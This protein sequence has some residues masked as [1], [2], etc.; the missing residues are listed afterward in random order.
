MAS[1]RVADS[2]PSLDKQHGLQGP[3]DDAFM[4][5]FVNVAPT[6]KPMNEEGR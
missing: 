1:R 4:D 2:T 5:A 3:I 6:G